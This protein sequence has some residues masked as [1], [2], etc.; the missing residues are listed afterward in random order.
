MSLA[1][2]A[3]SDYRPY[4]DTY[5][6][7]RSV[8]AFEIWMKLFKQ[9]QT[10]GKKIAIYTNQASW[11]GR[12]PVLSSRRD[13]S[14]AWENGIDEYALW[15]MEVYP[16]R[17]YSY[18]YGSNHR[19]LIDVFPEHQSISQMVYFRR[20]NKFFK[21]ISCKR[22]ESIRDGV[23]D[24]MYLTILSSLIDQ[25]AQPVSVIPVDTV[26]H[27]RRQLQH[28]CISPKMTGADF[29]RHKVMPAECI[30]ELD[31]LLSPYQR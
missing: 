23:K 6:C 21:P 9:E 17:G 2:W 22:L 11:A 12:S 14:W 25:A 20:E 30:I 7:G 28:V 29:A 27:Y 15:T 13:L 16:P 19:S 24:Y 1:R 18:P 31:R 10:H 4:V 26:D 5:M 3:D 8:A